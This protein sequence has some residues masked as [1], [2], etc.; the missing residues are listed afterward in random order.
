MAGTVK[1]VTISANAH[2]IETMT[3]FPR[4]PIATSKTNHTSNIGRITPR[5]LLVQLTNISGSTTVIPMDI[6]VI[7]IETVVMLEAGIM[8]EVTTML[9]VATM[10][11]TMIV[12]MAEVAIM[13]GAANLIEVVTM[14]GSGTEIGGGKV[15]ELGTGAETTGGGAEEVKGSEIGIQWTL[16]TEEMRSR[17]I[18]TLRLVLTRATE[19]GKGL[20]RGLKQALERVLTKGLE[21]GSERGLAAERGSIK[22]SE[23]GVGRVWTWACPHLSLLMTVRQSSAR[24]TR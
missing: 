14:I 11:V 9:K 12:T 23:R 3:T 16:G 1:V 19:R 15:G 20:G 13:N 22:A 10:I 6:T 18:I 24:T 5:K 4:D 7:F 17:I 2:G 21:R 8:T